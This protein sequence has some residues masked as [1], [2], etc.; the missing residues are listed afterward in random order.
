V[1]HAHDEHA[2]CTHEGAPWWHL[3][4]QKSQI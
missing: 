1:E 2:T 4:T 3:H